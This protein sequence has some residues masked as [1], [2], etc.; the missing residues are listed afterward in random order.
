[1]DAARKAWR[2][3]LPDR[4]KVITGLMSEEEARAKRDLLPLKP[5]TGERVPTDAEV[6]RWLDT[7]TLGW[8]LEGV[9]HGVGRTIWVCSTHTGVKGHGVTPVDARWALADKLGYKPCVLEVKDPGWWHHE[10]GGVILD[11]PGFDFRSKVEVQGEDLVITSGKDV[12]H[13]LRVRLNKLMECPAGGECAGVGRQKDPGW[14]LDE[15]GK[16]V[17]DGPAGGYRVLIRVLG[18][19]L[20]VRSGQ[21]TVREFKV[22]LGKLLEDAWVVQ[23][24]VKTA[25]ELELEDCLRE[26]RKVAGLG[27]QDC[28]TAL[29]KRL[30]GMRSGEGG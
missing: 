27:A 18:D 14:W 30:E 16:A 9:R 1:M 21:G 10:A 19:D 24:A 7:N 28:V 4:V 5:L 6:V 29:R 13:P 26:C 11:G 23:R 12:A 3:G 20:V 15:P 25:H 8:G 22:K 2:E 17:L